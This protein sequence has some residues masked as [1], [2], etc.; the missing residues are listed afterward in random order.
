MAIRS[1]MG[2]T[3]FPRESGCSSLSH[4]VALN[5]PGRPQDVGRRTSGGLRAKAHPLWTP[6]FTHALHLARGTL[7]SA[8]L[9]R[10]AS[11]RSMCPSHLRPLL[12]PD[13]GPRLELHLG[14]GFNLGLVHSASSSTHSWSAP[15]TLPYFGVQHNPGVSSAGLRIHWEADRVHMRSLGRRWAHCKLCVTAHQTLMAPS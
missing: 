14:C 11:P 5:L 9:P 8:Q 4:S 6:A 2:V 15:P 12:P 13:P 3:W 7:L 1:M 10:P